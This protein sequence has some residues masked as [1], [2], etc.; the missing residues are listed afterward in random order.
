MFFN[1]VYK[2][3]H[4]QQQQQVEQKQNVETDATSGNLHMQR[5]F[6]ISNSLTVTN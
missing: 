1:C 5:E 4:Q 2:N 6:S 3:N